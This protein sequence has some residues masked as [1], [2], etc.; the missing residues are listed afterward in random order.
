MSTNRKGSARSVE[1]EI[2]KAK[3]E[4]DLIEA[5]ARLRQAEAMFAQHST[6]LWEK[7]VVRGIIPIALLI[8][9][10]MA[11]AYFSN[12]V[13]QAKTEVREVAATAAALGSLV[14]AQE[15]EAEQYRQRFQELEA[16]KAAELDEMSSVVTRLD[17][18]LRASMIQLA[19]MQIINEQSTGGNIPTEQEVLRQV[20]D[21]VE[22]PGV[23]E[24]EI[25][26]IAAQ[27]FQR[28]ESRK[29]GK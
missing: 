18:T 23:D 27:T 7:I 17:K 20:A 11:T 21:Q 10:P 24:R 29:G 25:S 1:I 8:V 4:A 15:T 16:Q 12:E 14:K 28:F 26:K 2:A 19:V 6:S 3:A 13:Q 9:G 22:L 5:Q